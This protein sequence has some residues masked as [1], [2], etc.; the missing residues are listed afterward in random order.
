MAD[1]DQ[2]SLTPTPSPANPGEGVMRRTAAHRYAGTLGGYAV[3][4]TQLGR[5]PNR[6]LGEPPNDAWTVWVSH[7]KRYT[8]LCLTRA[9]LRGAL[10]EVRAWV[11]G[12]PLRR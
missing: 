6:P 1:E 10:A 2:Q 7:P 11:A 4:A 8:C 12:H 3:E 5:R 9:S